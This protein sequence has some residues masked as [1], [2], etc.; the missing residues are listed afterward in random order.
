MQ[1][2]LFRLLCRPSPCFLLPSRNAWC[3]VREQEKAPE[4]LEAMP[5]D[6]V[7]L[8][9]LASFQKSVEVRWSLSTVAA[10]GCSVCSRVFEPVCSVFLLA[11]V[12]HLLI[13]SCLR[14]PSV[15]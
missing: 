9:H 11:S 7:W 10:C 3:V 5:S 2:I 14:P 6:D 12:L 13:V 15:L 4:P 1:W 8:R